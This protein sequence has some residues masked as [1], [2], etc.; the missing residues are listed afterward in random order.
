M[1]VAGVVAKVTSPLAAVVGAGGVLPHIL[2]LNHFYFS[3]C[4][5]TG[6]ISTLVCFCEHRSLQC[7]QM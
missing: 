4:Q 6:V 3:T 7:S 2:S 1:D 5:G